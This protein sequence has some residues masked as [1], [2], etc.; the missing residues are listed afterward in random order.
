MT[1]EIDIIVEARGKVYGHPLD[2]FT[3]AAVIKSA[4]NEM[5]DPVLQHAADMIA[6][7]LSR[8]V[9]SPDHED[10]WRDIAGYARCA[11]MVIQERR[12]RQD[13]SQGVY[14]DGR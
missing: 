9:N 10:S 14:Q 2:D 12:V 5:N 4:F 7:K 1:D 13:Q 8:L 11:L 6:T 3:R